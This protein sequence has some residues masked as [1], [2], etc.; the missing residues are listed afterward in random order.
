MCILGLQSDNTGSDARFERDCAIRWHKKS[1]RRPLCDVIRVD[2]DMSLFF[3]I[4]RNENRTQ[5]AWVKCRSSKGMANCRGGMGNR[6]SLWVTSSL[7]SQKR[8]RWLQYCA[9]DAIA[10]QEDVAAHFAWHSL[11]LPTW[12]S[13][14]F[15]LEPRSN[16]VMPLQ[17]STQRSFPQTCLVAQLDYCDSWKSVIHSLLTCGH[18]VLDACMASSDM[19]N[20]IQTQVEGY[21]CKNNVYARSTLSTLSQR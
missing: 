1:S 15:N 17:A 20:V 13:P 10:F 12:R 21:P 5:P 18:L 11:P 3:Q 19:H 2:N 6:D 9:I 4:N 14:R 7:Q 16:I 8:G